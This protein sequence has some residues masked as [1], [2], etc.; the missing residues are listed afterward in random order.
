RPEPFRVRT[1]DHYV[2][3]LCK[4]CGLTEP[5][6]EWGQSSSRDAGRPR[7]DLRPLNEDPDEAVSEAVGLISLR[8]LPKDLLSRAM[9]DDADVRRGCANGIRL[10]EWVEIAR[11]PGLAQD[12]TENVAFTL[13]NL[14]HLG[15]FFLD[16]KEPFIELAVIDDQVFVI[17]PF[18]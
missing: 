12:R 1:T 13:H 2:D 14:E 9:A 15:E 18:A 4:V 8:E 11:V 16:D 17:E 7:D 3:A 5:P 6:H 10:G